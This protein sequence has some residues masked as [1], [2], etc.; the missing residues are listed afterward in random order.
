MLRETK[1]IL[2]TADRLVRKKIPLATILIYLACST[3]YAI[4]SILIFNRIPNVR[5]I[6]LY[7]ATTGFF[8]T[9]YLVAIRKMT[10]TYISDRNRIGEELDFLSLIS[11]NTNDLLVLLD[12]FGIV[13]NINTAFGKLLNIDIKA[14]IGKPFRDMFNLSSIDNTLFFRRMILDNLNEIFRMRTSD[15][16]LPVKLPAYDDN[17]SVY[18][19]LMPIA[20]EGK[21]KNILAIGRLLGSD[22]ITNKWLK[23]EQT[24][25]EMDNSVSYLIL[26]CHRLTRNLEGKLSHNEI[27]LLQIALQEILINAIEHGNLEIDYNTKTELKKTD[28][29]YLNVL[30]QKG[31][32]ANKKNKKVFI[33]YTLDD[34]KAMYS[35][36]DQGKGFDWKHFMSLDVENFSGDL[37]KSYHG[38]GLQMVKS[39]FDEISYNEKGNEVT[40]VKYFLAGMK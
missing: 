36:V 33:T 30:L 16:I 28:S 27:V 35:I 9:A 23:H 21:L 15:F 31:V 32:E 8:T 38:V 14:A 40:L 17:K 19:K 7:L 6:L 1:S 29:N 25:Y 11:E 37:T 34:K 13:I 5:E 2:G 3:G 4:I 24:V 22:Y 12:E 20:V 39:A 10:A 18:I 26:F